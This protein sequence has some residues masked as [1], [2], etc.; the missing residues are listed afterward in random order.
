MMNRATTPT[1]GAITCDEP[2]GRSRWSLATARAGVAG[3][4]L[5]AL[6]VIPGASGADLPST[7]SGDWVVDGQLNVI[8]R[9]ADTTYLGGSFTMIGPNC[10]Y[11]VPLS[12]TSGQPVAAY[13]KVNGLVYCCAPDGTGG[14]YIGGTFTK[15]GALARNRL[16]HIKADGTVDAAWDPK[17]N[18]TVKALTVSGSTVYVGGSFTTLGV[19]TRNRLAAIGTDGTLGSWDPNANSTV[20]AL[21]ISGST[22]YAG[23]DFSTIGGTTRNCLAA[24]DTNGTLGSWNPNAGYGSTVMALAVS[25]STVY[26]GGSFT[27]IGVTTRNRL[28]AI[29]TDGTL[30][31]WNPNANNWVNALAVSD[32]TVYVGGSFTT[33]GGTTRNRLAAI[34]TDGTLGAWDPNA[35]ATVYSLAVASGGIPVYAG[36]LFSTLGGAPCRSFAQ[37]GVAHTPTT[38]TLDSSANPSTYG[39]SVTLTATISPSAATGTVTFKDGATTLGTGTLSS[40]TAT[41]ATAALSAGSHSLTAEYAGDSTYDVSTSSA[42]TQTVNKGTPSV[43]TWPTASAITAG[44]ALSASTLSGGSAS[45]AGGFTF[46]APATTPPAGTYSAAVTFTPTDTANYNTVAGSVNVVVTAAE[47]ATRTPSQSGAW[48]D[49]ATWGGTLPAAGDNVVLPAGITVTLA[50]PIG[51]FANLTIAGTLNLG[52]N[53]LQVSGNLTVT[54]TFNPGTGTVELTG[55]ADQTLAATAPGTLTFYNLKVNKSPTTAKVTATSKLKASKKLTITSGKLV[56]ASDYGDVFIDTDGELQLTSDITVSGNFTNNGALSGDFGIT[57]DGGTEQNL[58]LLGATVFYNLTVAA[59]TTLIETDPNDNAVVTGTLVN[60]GVLRKTQPVIGTGEYIF[61][62]AG[63]LVGD[64]SDWLS[65]IVS[66]LTGGSPLTAIQVDCI[67]ANHPQAL[68]TNTTDIYWTITP[69]GSDFVADLV[70]PHTNLSEPQIGRYR[71]G[72]WD[73]GNSGFDPVTISRTDLT[74]FGDFAVFNNPQLVVST[75]TTLASSLNPSTPGQSVTFTATVSPSAA[76]GTVTFKDGATTLG[77]GTLSGGTA[78]FTTSALTAGNHSLTAEYA[79]DSSYGASTSGALSQTVEK[80]TPTVSTWPT[81]SAITTVG[82]ALSV[83]SL[84]GGSASVA[85]SFAWTAPATTPPA[86]NYS[87]AVTFT[88]TDTTNYNTVAGSVNV[89]VGLAAVADTVTRPAQ[90]LTKIAVA[91]L[92]ANDLDAAGRT[93]SISSVTAGSGGTVALSG[94]W[95]TFT[96]DVGL[97]DATPATFTYVLSNGTGSTTSATVT[98][99]APG[100]SY[101]T[102]PATLLQGGIVNNPGGP[103]KQLTFAAVPNFIYV[104]E[105][106]GDLNAWTPLGSFTAGADGRLVITDTG[107][108][109]A[110]RFYRFKK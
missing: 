90:G 11:G 65:I 95:I 109:E 60:H 81:A 83:S 44:Q 34:G 26:A 16:A 2:T 89:L 12:A 20:N 96:P 78:T 97:A 39:N 3:L 93:L 13:P 53:T 31:T 55:G 62:L 68:G 108:T 85:G 74:A 29:G 9:T 102:S 51:P 19:S 45:V 17:A 49:P 69:V 84:S 42:L 88:P 100:T 76:T 40:G 77:T 67:Y 86:G 43:T 106:S 70:L 23:G 72:A 110:A 35:D 66:D 30:G 61:G 107:A 14:W 64:T 82:Q 37:F 71:A 21:A 52:A 15:V 22:V 94:R 59:G 33:I 80:A 98:L 24:I 54:G 87:A 75:T 58:S 57:F 27:T 10:P 79:G 32:T 50:G 5:A 47:P 101:N 7:P 46:D 99:N 91:Q 73:W 105:V 103:G 28:A 36:G 92:L 41:Y 25:G 38:T 18:N 63:L 8:V 48:N 1:T 4:A 104:V 56:S 6:L